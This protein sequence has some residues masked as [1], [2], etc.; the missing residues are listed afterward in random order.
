MAM[1][2]MATMWAM[3]LALRLAG[4]KDDKG[5]GSKGN[6]DSDMRVAD[7]WPAMATKRAMGMAT[8]VVSMRQQQQWQQ[9]GLR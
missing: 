3:A 6:L 8:K 1:R 9:I 2:A 4:D 7:E 5:K